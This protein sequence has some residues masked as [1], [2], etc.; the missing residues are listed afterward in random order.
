MHMNGCAEIEGWQVSLPSG[1]QHF[2][3]QNFNF[4]FSVAMLRLT[5]I[6]ALQVI[7][8]NFATDFSI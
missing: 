8:H 7:D 3:F 1:Y 2:Q 5:S 4:K 6:Q